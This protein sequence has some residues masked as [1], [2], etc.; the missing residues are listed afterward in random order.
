MFE[1]S[2]SRESEHGTSSDGLHL[3]TLVN[4]LVDSIPMN[5]VSELH[6]KLVA[7]FNGYAD[8]L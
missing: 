4:V 1:T 3:I 8:G 7:A 6:P 5:D 2:A